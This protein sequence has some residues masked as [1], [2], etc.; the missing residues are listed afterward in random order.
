MDWN[1]VAAFINRT[2]DQQTFLKNKTKLANFPKKNRKNKQ[3]QQTFFK[4]ANLENRIVWGWAANC[5][6]RQRNPPQHVARVTTPFLLRTR[7]S[8]SATKTA[9]GML[10]PS[11]GE[12]QQEAHD[13]QALRLAGRVERRERQY[14]A[15]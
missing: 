5:L 12:I 15:K 3:N 6:P 2:N 13:L 8:E 11:I 9:S 1:Y 7:C 4:T 10:S 14:P